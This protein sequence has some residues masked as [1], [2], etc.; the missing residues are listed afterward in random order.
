[1]A[2]RASGIDWLENFLAQ[3]GATPAEILRREQQRQAANQVSIGNCV[4][5]LRLLSALDWT[6]FFERTSLVEALLREDPAE[7]YAGQDFPSRDRYRRVVEKLARGSGRTEL[8]VAHEVL[9]L[10]GHRGR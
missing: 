4:T 7:V 10:A 3:R 5:S 6:N 9:A 1:G 8:E 2:A